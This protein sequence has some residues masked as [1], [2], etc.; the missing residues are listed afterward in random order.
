M[1]ALVSLGHDVQGVD[2]EPV[3]PDGLPPQRRNLLSRIK[4][5]LL[6]GVGIACH[7]PTDGRAS[8]ELLTQMAARP[9][10]ILWMDKGLSIEAGVLEKVKRL[11][12]ECKIVGYSPDDMARVQNQSRQWLEHLYLYDFYFT[13]KSYNVSELKALG[14]KNPIFV[15]NAFCPKLHRPMPL[16]VADRLALGGA[17]GFIG[18]WEPERARSIYELAKAGIGVRIWGDGW[19]RCLRRHHNMHIEGR[20]LWAEEYTRAICS[21]D[22]NLC[23]LRKANRDLQTTRSIEIPACGGFMLA[24][25]SDEHLALFQE[26]REAEFF[27]SDKELVQK[28]IYYLKDPISRKRIAESG[29]RRCL[30]SGYSNEERL[31]WMLGVVQGAGEH[32]G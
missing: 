10:D 3:G 11:Q 12:A 7:H 1:A 14:C 8:R 20:P 16:S 26:G 9:W 32:H 19:N 15:G 23:F 4:R 31:A 29:R 17:V 24:E 28:V 21:F 30:T 2:T 25:R 22:I 27:S 13:T 6:N 18:S 5:K